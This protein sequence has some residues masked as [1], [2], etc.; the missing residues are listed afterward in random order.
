MPLL[1]IGVSQDRPNDLGDNSYKRAFELTLLETP[2][3]PV[4][5]KRQGFHWWRERRSEVQQDSET[6]PPLLDMQPWFRS[7]PKEIRD[8]LTEPKAAPRFFTSRPAEVS[9]IWQDYR[10]NPF[11]WANSLL[12]HLLVLNG[13]GA[14]F[15]ASTPDAFRASPHETI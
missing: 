13:A 15:R 2:P 8:V 6:R 5:L 9:H 11:S 10:L 12:I 7:L 3:L 1:P 4:S 14:A